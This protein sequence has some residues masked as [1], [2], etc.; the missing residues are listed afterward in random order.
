V[1]RPQV[2]Y[3]YHPPAT[4][5]IPALMLRAIHRARLVY[6][7]QDMWPDTVVATGMMPFRWVI[8]LLSLLC[9]TIY[10][11]ADHL[12]VL[13]PG[14]KLALIERGVPSDKISVIYNWCDEA[15]VSSSDGT[16]PAAQ[17]L[18]EWAGKFLVLFAGTMGAAQS[19]DTVLDA[20][21]SAVPACSF[22]F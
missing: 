4:V 10:A 9:S 13:S 6:D 3:A 19:L 8:G 1:D 14:F 22:C 21:G 17:R 20:A 18:D 11:Y 2:I 12:T 5:G 15:N 7:I 16:G